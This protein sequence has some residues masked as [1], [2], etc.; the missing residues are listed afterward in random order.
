V[1]TT[2]Q[3]DSHIASV[4]DLLFTGWSKFRY[5]KSGAICQGI[6]ALELQAQQHG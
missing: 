6:A 1:A 4:F 3:H 5:T 2:Y